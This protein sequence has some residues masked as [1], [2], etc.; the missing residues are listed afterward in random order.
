[1]HAVEAGFVVLKDLVGGLVGCAGSGLGVLL[2][3]F[4]GI[5]EM[6]FEVSPGLASWKLA[7][8]VI[9]FAAGKVEVACLAEVTECHVDEVRVGDVLTTLL[10]VA[11]VVLKPFEVDGGLFF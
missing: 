11:L 1:M 3:Y 6:L 4:S 10:G 9:P 5:G 2:G 7:D 8:E